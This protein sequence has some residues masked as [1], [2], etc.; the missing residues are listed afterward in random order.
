MVLPLNVVDIGEMPAALQAVLD[1]FSR[2]DVLINNAGLGARG[3][4]LDISMDVYREVMEVNL[5]GATQSVNRSPKCIEHLHGVEEVPGGERVRGL[6][7]LPRRI[8]ERE[9]GQ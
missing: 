8:G 4:V 9:H 1:R 6:H 3:S 5:F 7:L 2:V